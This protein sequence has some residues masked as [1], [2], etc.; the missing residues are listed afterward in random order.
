MLL[1]NGANHVRHGDFPCCKIW[2]DGLTPF[3]RLLGDVG[4]TS[5]G[6]PGITFQR[7]GS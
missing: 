2:F 4:L 5:K 7:V 3:L 6:L 1:G